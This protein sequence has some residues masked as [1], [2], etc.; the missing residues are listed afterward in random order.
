MAD[1]RSGR[2]RTLQ[3]EY[4]FDRLLPEKLAQAYE[5]L[6]PTKARSMVRAIAEQ[7]SGDQEVLSDATS[8]DLHPCVLGPP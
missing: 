7:N 1:R 2:P 3:T 6:A 8:C 5:L 4:L